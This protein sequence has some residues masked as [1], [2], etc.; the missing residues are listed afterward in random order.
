MLVAL[1]VPGMSP[2]A[3][4][5]TTP[6]SPT[7]TPMP[8]QTPGA[9][10]APAPGRTPAVPVAP[11][12]LPGRVLWTTPLDRPA[13]AGGAMDDARIYVPLQPERLVALAREDGRVLWTRDIETASPPLRL[14]GLLFVTASD[15]LHAIDP[16]TGDERWRIPFEHEPGAVVLAAG[17]RLVGVI[18]PGVLV[19]LDA[20]TGTQVWRHPLDTDVPPRLAADATRVLLAQPDGRVLAVAANDG[21]LLWSQQVEAPAAVLTLTDTHAITAAGR[22]QVWSLRLEDGRPS[23]RWRVGAAAVAA[24]ADD[25]LLFLLS[26][27]NLLRAVNAGNGNQRWKKDAPGRPSAPPVVAGRTLIVAGAGAQVAG[28]AV[29]TGATAGMWTAPEDLLGSPLLTMPLPTTGPSLVLV[30]RDGRVIGIAPEVP[31][32]PAAPGSPATAP[33]GAPGAPPARPAPL[34]VPGSPAAPATARP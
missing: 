4:Q 28:Y 18:R 8:A 33:G 7:G 15:E 1:L 30:T 26:R 24:T 16:A 20:A 32:P 11:A 12:L 6:A 27:D 22:N 3:A 34:A 31:K 19:S 2:A 5:V 10:A 17:S 25:G 13:A 14:G 23:W 29:T 21:H 9:T